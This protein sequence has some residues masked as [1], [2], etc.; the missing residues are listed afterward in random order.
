MLYLY[1]QDIHNSIFYQKFS[2][3]G[4]I[5]NSVEEQ[6]YVGRCVSDVLTLLNYNILSIA[7]TRKAG[8]PTFLEIIKKPVHAR[9]DVPQ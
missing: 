7:R 2:W 6:S 9:V 3:Y 4:W 1:L 8:H 5:R